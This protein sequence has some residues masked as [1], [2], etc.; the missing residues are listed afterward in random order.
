MWLTFAVA[1]TVRVLVSCRSSK[2]RNTC[3]SSFGVLALLVR[4]VSYI[5]L[6]NEPVSLR[7][8]CKHSKVFRFS[9]RLEENR[10]PY[11]GTG[12]SRAF[13]SATS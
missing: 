1:D 11:R 4:P 2:S 5:P 6:T 13:P 7:H 12:H 8:R 10:S 9:K 3:S